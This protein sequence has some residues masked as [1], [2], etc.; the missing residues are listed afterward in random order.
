[1]AF[2]PF[3]REQVTDQAVF[4]VTSHPVRFWFILSLTERMVVQ[5]GKRESK[6][7]AGFVALVCLF[8][9]SKLSYLQDFVKSPQ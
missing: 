2:V 5:G 3:G 7:T 1:M 4:Y 9:L 6:G 8:G